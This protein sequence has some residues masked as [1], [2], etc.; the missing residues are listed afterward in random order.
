MLS[1]YERAFLCFSVHK[2]Q[3]PRNTI[4]T[5]CSRCNEIEERF[6][7]YGIGDKFSQSSVQ[8]H[9]GKGLTKFGRP[10]PTDRSLISRSGGR[11]EQHFHVVALLAFDLAKIINCIYLCP[12]PPRACTVLDLVAYYI[13]VFG[14]RK[15]H[16]PRHFEMLGL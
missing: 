10:D 1:E 12:L 14:F 4:R 15:S 3:V 8:N 13:I 7:D 11:S 16:A 6:F 5:M 2:V 9:S